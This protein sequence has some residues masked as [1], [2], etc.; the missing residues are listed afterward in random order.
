MKRLLALP[1][2]LLG[3]RGIPYMSRPAFRYDMISIVFLGLASGTLSPSFTQLFARKSL[4]AEPWLVAA[5]LAQMALGNFVGGFLSSWLQRRRRI[6]VLV[7]AKLGTAGVMLL[8]AMLPAHGQSA[9]A[10]V[11]LLTV[12]A[13]LM[14]VVRMV[15]SGV[16]H[17]NYPTE[18]RGKIFSRRMV[19]NM[20]TMILAIK[21]SGYALDHWSGAHRVI[22]ALGAMCMIVS[23]AVYSRIRVRG[24]RRMLKADRGE[25]RLDVLEGFRLLRRDPVYGRYMAWQML[26]ACTVI[27]TAPAMVL[28]LTDYLEVDYARGTTAM[29]LVPLGVSMLLCPLAGRL[30][31]SMGATRLRSLT[32]LLWASSRAL[33][34]PALILRSWPMVLLAFAAQGAAL[35]SGSIVFHI[36]HTHFARPRQSQLYMGIHLTLQG[37]RGLTMPFLGVWLYSLKGIEMSLLGLAAAVQLVAMMGFLLSPNPAETGG[38]SDRELPKYADS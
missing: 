18:L 15:F 16:W 5:L 31:D 34:F 11:A 25:K 22:Y 27:M 35:S 24:E 1:K 12:P 19:V 4:H 6:S 23:A 37:L 14:A 13:I 28:M 26:S 10:F 38:A 3:Y 30:F 33:L 21:L 8:V 20:A 17:S 9:A 29:A 7:A 36:G 2:W 32:A